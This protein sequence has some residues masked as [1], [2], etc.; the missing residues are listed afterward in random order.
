MIGM[1]MCDQDPF[2]V[3]RG[4]VELGQAGGERSPF[5]RAAQVDD[6]CGAAF[7]EDVEVVA[8]RPEYVGVV[9]DLSDCARLRVE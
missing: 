2:D 4:Q 1:S 9:G 8:L 6:G 7:R 3:A 5:A